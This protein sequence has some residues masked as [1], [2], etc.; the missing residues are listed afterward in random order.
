MAGMTSAMSATSR[1]SQ[2]RIPSRISD[3]S[4]RSAKASERR[5][6]GSPPREASET[7]LKQAAVASSRTRPCRMPTTTC[8]PM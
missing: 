5:A 8:A 6:A 1:P 3:G 4:R 2:P 7:A